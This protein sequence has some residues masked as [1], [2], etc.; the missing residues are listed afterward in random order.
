[1]L[2]WLIF[3]S[4]IILGILLPP[5]DVAKEAIIPLL[6]ILMTFST[7]KLRFRIGRKLIFHA[8]NCFLINYIFLTSV[9][10][11]ASYLLI[12][13]EDHLRGFIVMAAIPPAIGIVPFSFLLK[14]DVEVA[15][16]GEIFCYLLSLFFAP[17]LIFLL[18]SEE[19]DPLY[20][21]Q[22]LL[23]LIFLPLLLSRLIPSHPLEKIVIP[24]SFAGI[25]YIVIGLNQ[26]YLYAP[27]LLPLF[28]V[29]FLRTFVTGTSFL[30][31]KRILEREKAITY[32]L[33]AS[34]KNLG[35]TAGIAIA[36]FGIE[37][38]LPAAIGIIFE[39]FYIIYFGLAGSRM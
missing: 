30:L 22:L 6:I 19:I 20:L 4:A 27:F 9:I 12:Q 14:G 34:Y 15:V 18:L 13:N 39:I 32:S 3:L 1:M 29:S 31:F 11:F 16:A 26:G 2:Q 24:L 38:S 10:I 36:L 17:F 25:I 33:F 21:L 37:A 35:A 8:F 23:L 28:I 7:T 5:P